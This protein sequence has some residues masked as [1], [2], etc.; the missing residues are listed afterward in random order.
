VPVGVSG[1]CVWGCV[2]FSNFQKSQKSQKSQKTKKNQGVCQWL[3]Q[4]GVS[5]GVSI[6]QIFK[7][8]KNLKNHKNLKK[9]KKIISDFLNFQFSNFPIFRFSNFDLNSMEDDK[10]CPEVQ[11]KNLLGPALYRSFTSLLHFWTLWALLGILRPTCIF[12][13]QIGKKL[14]HF[15]KSLLVEHGVPDHP[16]TKEVEVEGSQF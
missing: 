13:I 5:G 4:V 9:Q 2:N 14:R 8:F 10:K 1:G 11:I 15:L 6:F 12:S 7:M 16:T 3:C